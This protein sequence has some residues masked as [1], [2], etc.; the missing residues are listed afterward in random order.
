MHDSCWTVWILRFRI[1][2][3][4]L[5]AGLTVWLGLRATGLRLEWDEQ[6]EFAGR[7]ARMAEF[8]R[9][10]ERFGGEEYL[11]VAL[12]AD[13]VFTPDTLALLGTLTE[14]LREVPRAAEVLSLANVPAVRSGPEGIRIEPFCGAPPADAAAAEALRQEALANPAW[15]GGL[16]SADGRMACINV[17][18]PALNRNVNERLEAVAAVQAILRRH[19][20]PGVR[21]LVT[22]YSPLAADML[23]TLRSDVNRFLWMTPVVV[24]GLLALAFRTWRSV[25]VP[26]VAI[27]AA[28]AWTLGLLALGGGTLNLC[29][30]LLPTLVAINCL[31]YVIHLLNAYHD[32]CAR[33]RDHRRILALT[34]AH[35]APPLF[36]AAMTTAIGFG[37]QTL[38]EIRSLRQ[39]GLYSAAGILAA[40]GVCT[41]VVPA[42]LAYLP[43]PARTAHRHHSVRRLRRFLWQAAGAAARDRWKT[44][45]ALALLFAAATAGMWRIRVES[46]ATRDLPP[47]A[48]SIQG[49]RAVE[50][51]L[52]GF[53]VLEVMVEGPP[54]AFQ[55]PWALEQLDRLQRHAAAQ[56]GV[57]QAVSLNDLFRQ[58][59]RVR[60]PAAAAAGAA[61]T[62]GQ[63]AEYRLLY[64]VAGQD[65]LA[66][67]FVSRDAGAAR[68]AVRIRNLGTTEQ[69][70]LVEDIA[71]FARRELDPRLAVC[72]TGV[73]KMYA[74]TMH[75]LVRSLAKSFGFAC[76]LIMAALAVQLRSLRAGLCAMIPNLLPVALAFGVM[77]YLDI[78]LTASTVMVAS[79]GIGLAVDDTIHFLLRSRRELR[80]GRTPLAAARRTLLG[81]GRAMVYSALGLAAGFSILGFSRFQ[82]NREFGLLTAFILVVALAAD[83]CVTP[84]LVC[85]FRLFQE[86]KP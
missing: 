44:P 8:R 54:G 24:L 2:I 27:G 64:S 79:V 62:S 48:P 57:D 31:S 72:T 21:A 55:E 68:L 10:Q 9:F 67:S 25:W 63:I 58:I 75:A 16:V 84:W 11:L 12:Q 5:A 86:K 47:D 74:A 82:L 76:L 3:L 39:L 41:V 50:A 69:L 6:A 30:V 14:A 17:M 38:S 78:P 19:G 70:R 22:G 71:A 35:L 40:F 29:T 51:G 37:T 85:A 56:P 34:V 20:Q 59:Q 1:P 15:T 42:M 43:M 53:H 66:G 7:D 77:G 28:V 18:L 49:L 81:T 26:A 65:R 33:G 83:L 73:V 46:N 4:A 60:E 80:P 32:G 13:N 61:W 45:A 23:A 52:A 36:M